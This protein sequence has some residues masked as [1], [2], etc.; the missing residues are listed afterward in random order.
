VARRQM[1]ARAR[2]EAAAD[3]CGAVHRGHPG[4]PRNWQDAGRSMSC[5]GPSDAIVSC[6]SDT[7]AAR[8][9]AAR[10]LDQ[11][12]QAKTLALTNPVVTAS[13][14]RIASS[15]DRSSKFPVFLL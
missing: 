9:V 3:L 15:N 6:T 7:C 8:T 4:G 5:T 12:A 10:V 1:V 13:F 14:A 2:L 11:H